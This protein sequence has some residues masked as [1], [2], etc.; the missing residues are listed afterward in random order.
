MPTILESV[1]PGKI[2]NQASPKEEMPVKTLIPS[3]IIVCTTAWFM[4]EPEV[5]FW[6]TTTTTLLKP[7]VKALSS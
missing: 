7:G 6:S 5:A 2:D 1:I 4:V 3:S